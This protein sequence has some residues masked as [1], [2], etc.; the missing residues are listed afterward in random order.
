MAEEIWRNAN[1]NVTRFLETIGSERK[2]VLSYETLVTHPE[3]EMRR[4]AEFLDIPYTTA[5]L[6]PYDGGRMTDPV[7]AGA[8]DG[9]SGGPGAGVRRH[10]RDVDGYASEK[11]APAYEVRSPRQGRRG[12]NHRGDRP[13][14]RGT[15]DPGCNP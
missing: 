8:V 3:Q 5:L 9:G 12:A 7:T 1:Q 4:L 6:T 10:V 14:G 2:L 15:D 11:R 13:F